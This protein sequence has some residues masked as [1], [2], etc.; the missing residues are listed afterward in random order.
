[1]H[2]TLKTVFGVCCWV[3]QPDEPTSGF[4][5]VTTTLRSRRTIIGENSVSRE[6]DGRF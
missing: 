6:R 2:L 3:D 4:M 5:R 1:M